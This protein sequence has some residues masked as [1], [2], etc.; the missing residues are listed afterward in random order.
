MTMKWIVSA[1]LVGMVALTATANA[2][3]VIGT[4][5]IACQSGE[6]PAIQ[7]NIAG[8]KDRK[9]RLKLELYPANA[10]DFLKDD[11]DLRTEGKV[12]RR[13]WASTPA[14]GP[15]ELCIKVPHPGRYALFF[16]HDRDDKNKFNFWSD[17][18]GVPS[19]QKLGRSR[20]KVDQAVITVGSGVTVTNIRAQYLHGLGGFSPE[21]TAN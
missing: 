5:A 12:F 7:A 1:A 18:A 19:N 20:P 11:R 14:Q 17:G 8:L 2:S 21:K 10:D 13:V 15:V 4:D 9:G 3:V 16:T 6:G